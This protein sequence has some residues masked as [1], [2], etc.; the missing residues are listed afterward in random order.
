MKSRKTKKPKTKAKKT[1]AV[2]V[3]YLRALRRAVGRQIDPETAEFDWTNAPTDDPYSDHRLRAQEKQVGREYFARSPGSDL[4]VWLGDLPE[5]AA[6]VLWKRIKS[7]HEYYCS[8][9]GK[10]GCGRDTL[11]V[12]QVGGDWKDV[13]WA[14]GRCLAKDDVGDAVKSLERLGLRQA[15]F[16]ARDTV[17]W[18]DAA[19]KQLASAKDCLISK[20][21][22]PNQWK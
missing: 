8:C 18:L 17:N 4:W 10:G 9:C 6:D 2:A 7:D 15:K 22:W 16:D 5:V 11:K 19:I 3:K 13:V 12:V 21:M 14:H 20:G 1:V